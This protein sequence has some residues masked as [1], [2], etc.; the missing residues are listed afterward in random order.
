MDNIKHRKA[1]SKRLQRAFRIANAK[2]SKALPTLPLIV[3]A[4]IHYMFAYF[5]PEI[6][7]EIRTAKSRI[8][9]SFDG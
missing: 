1:A 5:K 4:W 3:A 9:I 7:K 8:T 6:I 2:A